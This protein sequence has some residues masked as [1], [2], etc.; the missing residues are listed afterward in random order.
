MINKTE[1]FRK[2]GGILEEL[3]EQYQYIA[4]NPGNF[5]S[6]ELELFSANADFLSEHTRILLK[7]SEDKSE[8]PVV[9]NAVKTQP[10]E[11]FQKV[12]AA[13]VK[14]IELPEITV[15][16]VSSELPSVSSEVKDNETM[17]V[18]DAGRTI[19]QPTIGEVTVPP[20][21]GE[22]K[23]ERDLIANVEP[24]VPTEVPMTDCHSL[25]AQES[26][27]GNGNAV[28]LP[29]AEE[30]GRPLEASHTAMG[31]INSA[32]K[33]APTINDLI[34]GS[35]EKPAVSSTYTPRAITDLKSSISLNDKLLF[36]KDLFNGYS[37]AYSE[38]IEI[39]NRFDSFEAADHFLQ[40]NYALK[41]NWAGK[42]ASAEKFYE[43]IRKK[44]PH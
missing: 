35:R 1:I 17:G 44:F 39:L 26:P 4:E 29:R 25:S 27:E 40:A 8:K 18:S 7:L 38:A 20:V 10:Q 9:G 24:S 11:S 28:S 12:E 33:P 13:P 14:A 43:V 34:S 42:K 5:S 23:P 32:H 21:G 16:S 19:V 37:L 22:R 36:I 2:I 31:S 6:L 3:N 15:P 30:T 41:N